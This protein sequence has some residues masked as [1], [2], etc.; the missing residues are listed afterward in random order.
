MTIQAYHRPET[1][2]EA[3]QLL[4][5]PGDIAILAGGTSLVAANQATEVVDLQALPLTD[6][7]VSTSSA[8]IGAM[9]R[10]QGIVSNEALP[11]FIRQIAQR[12]EINTFR[13]AGTLGG[14]IARADNESELYAALLAFD[15]SLHYIDTAGSHSMSL[16]DYRPGQIDK[17]IITG[18]T[19]QRG[20]MAA[21]ERVARTPADRPIVAI[22]GRKTD[23]TIQL[24][25][26]GVAPTPI[27]ITI[28]QIPM[29]NP[30]AD[31]R[32]STTYRRQMASVLSQR[33]L[34]HLTNI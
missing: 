9:V 8:T 10:L 1:V 6:I 22:I 2:A 31:F 3:L 15:G 33:I 18:V 7:E 28:D 20:G 24:I 13:N 21:Y 17:G 32:G 34:S 16:A 30:P 25:A 26:C 19:I 4:N 27:P 29:L 23:T 5:R 11:L 14:L 12:E